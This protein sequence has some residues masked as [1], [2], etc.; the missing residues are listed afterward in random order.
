MIAYAA[1]FL[2]AVLWAPLRLIWPGGWESFEASGIV[3]FLPNIVLGAVGILW[4]AKK[5]RAELEA[6]AAEAEA[7]P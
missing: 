4:V 2:V 5:G 1:L 6:E 3:M 7:Q